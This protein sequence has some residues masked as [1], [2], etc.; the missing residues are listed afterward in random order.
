MG[1][2]GERSSS[3]P[4]SSRRTV[5]LKGIAGSPGVATGSVVVVDTKRIGVAHRHVSTSRVDDEVERFQDA[6]RVAE[7]AVP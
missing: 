7:K 5:L 6:V 4:A 1:D 2:R 3:V